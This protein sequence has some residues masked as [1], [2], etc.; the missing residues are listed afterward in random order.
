MNKHVVVVGNNATLGEMIA[1]GSKVFQNRV[2]AG[3]RSKSQ[4]TKSLKATYGSGFSANLANTLIVLTPN[5]K[6]QLRSSFLAASCANTQ[7]TIACGLFFMSY[8]GRTEIGLTA[9]L[10]VKFLANTTDP[11]GKHL[12]HLN[13]P[14]EPNPTVIATHVA[15]MADHAFL[16]QRIVSHSSTPAATRLAP[17]APTTG[18]LM[19]ARSRL[20]HVETRATGSIPTW[21]LSEY[22]GVDLSFL[23]EDF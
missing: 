22:T 3:K 5:A 15:N 12:D 9:K 19:A 2:K 4:E 6:E 10:G 8:Q 23:D 20:K 11:A 17:A 13:T 18:A 21:A 1:Y 7:Y 14:N 16:A